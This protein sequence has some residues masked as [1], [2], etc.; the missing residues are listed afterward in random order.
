MVRT[1]GQTGEINVKYLKIEDSV[2]GLS[3]KEGFRNP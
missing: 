2:R 1:E 3:E